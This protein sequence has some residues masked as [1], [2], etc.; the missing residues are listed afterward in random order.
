MSTIV[1]YMM[2]Q[3]TILIQYRAAGHVRESHKTIQN[4]HMHY[5]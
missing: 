5:H 3:L 4:L 2:L 1:Q